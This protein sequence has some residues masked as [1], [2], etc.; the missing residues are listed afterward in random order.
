MPK[1]FT[2]PGESGYYC[3]VFKSGMDIWKSTGESDRIKAH[4]VANGQRAAL[5]G[6][7]NTDELFNSRSPG[8]RTC[9]RMSATNGASTMDI[10]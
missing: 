2:H 3:R 10:A 8:W 7:L 1:L 4:S 6:A 9:Q 5:V